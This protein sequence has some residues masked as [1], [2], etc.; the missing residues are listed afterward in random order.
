[1]SKVRVAV[2]VTRLGEILPIWRLFSLGSFFNYKSSANSLATVF[3][4]T[5]YV[6]VLTKDVFGYSLGDFFVNSSGHPGLQ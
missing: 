2:R 3:H 4:E 6:I 5:S 1:M